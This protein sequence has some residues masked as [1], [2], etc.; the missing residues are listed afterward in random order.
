MNW[1]MIVKEEDKELLER[2]NEVEDFKYLLE[3][4]DKEGVEYDVLYL[5]KQYEMI[6]SPFAEI[7]PEY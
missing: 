4:L 3:T 2:L 7:E 1:R 5:A 6:N